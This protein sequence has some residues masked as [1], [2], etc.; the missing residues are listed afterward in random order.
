MAIQDIT[1]DYLIGVWYDKVSPDA[2][3]IFLYIG[4]DTIRLYS[5]AKEYLQ[6]NPILKFDSDNNFFIISENIV[7]KIFENDEIVCCVNGEMDYCFVK[8]K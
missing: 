1:I 8:R 2:E 7:I 6:E 3:M 4:K 5:H